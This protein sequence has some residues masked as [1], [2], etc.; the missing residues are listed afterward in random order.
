MEDNVDSIA[1]LCGVDGEAT[2]TLRHPHAGL[3]L[4]ELHES[5]GAGV[6]SDLLGTALHN[7]LNHVGA[8]APVPLAP[9]EW[10]G[11]GAFSQV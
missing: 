2:I 7:A 8:G 5:G 3:V 11:G 6:I 9:A 1:I 4:R 10:E